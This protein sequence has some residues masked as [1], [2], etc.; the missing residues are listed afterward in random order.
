MPVTFYNWQAGLQPGAPYTRTSPNLTL[1]RAEL[2]KRFGGTYLGGYGVRT[3][4]A[5]ETWS[6]HAFG[7][8]IDWRIEDAA[9]RG[10]AIA[11]LVE[12]HAALGVQ[13]VHDYVGSRIWRAGRYPGQPASTWWRPQQPSTA[14]GMG[15][16]W[17]RWLHVE[18]DRSNWANDTP[19]VQRL[20]EQPAP[21]APSFDPAA[22]LWGRW[23][24]VQPKPTLRQVDGPVSVEHH[25][26]T[27]YLQGVLRRKAGQAIAVDGDFGPATDQAVRNLQQFFGLTVDGVVGPKTWAVLDMLAAR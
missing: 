5:G 11:W 18:T 22:G 27:R 2:G 15:Q 19:I 25:D 26:A 21:P 16:P 24:F 3:V 7:A 4:R 8:A 13:A 14:T 9:I 1:L 20:G 12:H 23:P 10:A 17:A 6:S